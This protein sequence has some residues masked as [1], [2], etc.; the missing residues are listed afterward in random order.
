MER[1]HMRLTIVN[2]EGGQTAVAMYSGYF[3]G[4]RGR[5]FWRM[6]I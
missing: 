3:S 6:Y 4:G 1:W 5:W 2:E